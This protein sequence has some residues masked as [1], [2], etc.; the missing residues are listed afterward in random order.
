MRN[1]H[2]NKAELGERLKW[3]P[4]Q[5]DRVLSVRHGSQFDQVEAALKALGKRVSITLEDFAQAVDNPRP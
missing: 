1:E 2:V 3:H 4:P 5:V